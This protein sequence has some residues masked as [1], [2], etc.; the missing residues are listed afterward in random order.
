MTF[1]EALSIFCNKYCVLR[2]QRDEPVMLS[3]FAEGLTVMMVAL[4]ES[5]EQENRD[6]LRA[7]IK[8]AL[9]SDA[10]PN[11]REMN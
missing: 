3:E 8:S 7:A 10:V 2:A 5:L 6:V 1:A 11:R 9:D 4:L